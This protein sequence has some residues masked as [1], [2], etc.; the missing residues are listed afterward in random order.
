MYVHMYISICIYVQIHILCVNAFPCNAK[1]EVETLSD[2]AQVVRVVPTVGLW[3]HGT[4]PLGAN[5]KPSQRRREIQG[6]LC[7]NGVN[8]VL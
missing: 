4:F 2:H 7:E 1:A 5:G 3:A 8:V 6:W